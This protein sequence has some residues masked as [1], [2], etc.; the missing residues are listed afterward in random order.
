MSSQKHVRV[1][2]RAPKKPCV[3]ELLAARIQRERALAAKM[4][5]PS[6]TEKLFPL[7]AAASRLGLSVW[8]L[9]HWAVEGRLNYRRLGRR[10]FITEAEISRI[11]GAEIRSVNAA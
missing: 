10:L 6:L 5:A 2:R 9:R 1:S 7:T 4:P 8:T 11:A 3:A